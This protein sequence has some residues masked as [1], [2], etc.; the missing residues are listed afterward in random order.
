MSGV[1]TLRSQDLENERGGFVQVNYSDEEFGIKESR[2]HSFNAPATEREAAEVVADLVRD[3]E[4]S[5]RRN[6][7]IQDLAVDIYNETEKREESRPAEGLAA[8]L[9]SGDGRGKGW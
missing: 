3:I 4:E 2:Y 5:M 7:R 8:R 1:T 6:A 9:R